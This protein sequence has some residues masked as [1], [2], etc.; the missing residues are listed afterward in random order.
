[1]NLKDEI[2][3]EIIKICRKYN[4]IEKVVLFGSRARENNFI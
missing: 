4:N 1:M 2:L 3:N